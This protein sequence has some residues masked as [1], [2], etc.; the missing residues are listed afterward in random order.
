MFLFLKV[1]NKGIKRIVSKSVSYFDSWKNIKINEINSVSKI[2]KLL[3]NY[4]KI[5]TDKIEIKKVIVKSLEYSKNQKKEIQQD[6]ITI[7][8]YN[9]KQLP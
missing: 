7:Y 5:F 6:L 4:N 9:K 1:K 3:Q 2:K 8:N